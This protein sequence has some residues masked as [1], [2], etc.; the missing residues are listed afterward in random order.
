[1]EGLI[2]GIHD[3][4]PGINPNDRED[5]LKRGVRLDERASGQGI[6]LS[7]VNEIVER[8]SGTLD[9]SSSSLGGVLLTIKFPAQ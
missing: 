9:I 8:Y 1:H 4:G 3:D 5:I 7:L 2:I 6:G